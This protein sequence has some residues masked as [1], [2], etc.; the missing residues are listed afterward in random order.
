MY[1]EVIFIRKNSRYSCSILR[2]KLIKCISFS[3]LNFKLGLLQLPDD[4]PF[5]TFSENS[6]W[7][8]IRHFSIYLRLLSWMVSRCRQKVYFPHLLL[9]RYLQK[10]ESLLSLINIFIHVFASK[11]IF[12]AIHFYS[13]SNNVIIFILNGQCKSNMVGKL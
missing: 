4:E 13:Q 12:K 6:H 1:A 11:Y 9:L 8:G 7:N 10:P 3:F 2:K 5:L